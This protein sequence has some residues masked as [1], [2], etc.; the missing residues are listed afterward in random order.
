MLNFKPAFINTVFAVTLVLVCALASRPAVVTVFKS[1]AKNAE[2]QKKLPIYCV[3]VPEKK[4]AITFD[5]AWGAA[6]T[7]ELISIL[8]DFDAKATFFVCGY[9][10]EKYPNEVKRL[11]EEGHLIGNHGDSH[12]HGAKLSLE[13]N[14]QEILR[15]HEKVKN[16]LAIDM[17]LFRPPFGEYNNTVL[18]AAE[19]ANYYTVQWDVDSHDWFIKSAEAEVNQVLKHKH[20]GGGSILLFHNDAKF[21]PE[22]LPAILKG[23]KDSGYE[24]VPLTELIYK[25]DYHINHEGRQILN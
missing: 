13:Q 8:N 18:D 1:Y 12:A 15:C 9:W 22:A 25:D 7:E 11:Y 16:L 23:L 17:N 4:I 14:R 5:A 20:L 21:T 3:D 19:T 24:I 6:D 2:A 10:V